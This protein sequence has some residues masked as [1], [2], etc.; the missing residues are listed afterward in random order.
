MK[1]GNSTINGSGKK[2]VSQTW[3]LSYVVYNLFSANKIEIKPETT[4]YKL[5]FID[6]ITFMNRSLSSLADNLLHK[7]EC[8]ACKC[9][10]R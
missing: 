2:I 3:N 1:K 7:N 10:L 6:S 8:K 5:K 4:K 9:C